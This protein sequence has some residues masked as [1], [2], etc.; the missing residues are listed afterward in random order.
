MKNISVFTIVSS[1][2]CR[3]RANISASY[4]AIASKS[5]ELPNLS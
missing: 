1:V 3:M 4:A 2:M 5:A